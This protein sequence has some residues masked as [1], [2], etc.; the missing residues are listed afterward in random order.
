[1]S[2]ISASGGM[3]AIP[4]KPVP[5]EYRL[6]GLDCFLWKPP[7]ICFP[8]GTVLNVTGVFL[9]YCFIF[10]SVWF[11]HLPISTKPAVPCM[12]G[13]YSLVPLICGINC[14]VVRSKTILVAVDLESDFLGGGGGGGGSLLSMGAAEVPV[15]T[16]V[17]P[18]PL[19]RSPGGAEES[20]EPPVPV[21]TS[22]LVGS[23]VF[24]FA[25]VVVLYINVPLDQRNSSILESYW[26]NVSA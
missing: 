4:P 21:A 24:T 26:K 7:D 12:M 17:N 10:S 13:R 3:T 20:R 8:K 23:V 6:L 9:S 5:P 16:G 25:G 19:A 14:A 15:A 11:S 18:Y 22:C 2:V 1:M